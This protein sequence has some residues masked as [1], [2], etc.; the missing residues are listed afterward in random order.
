MSSSGT[1]S[2]GDESIKTI[3]EAQFLE[4]HTK[5]ES[6]FKKKEIQIKDR[7]MTSGVLSIQEKGKNERVVIIKQGQEMQEIE[8]QLKK[9]IKP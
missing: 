5:F 7:I 6:I 2:G 1:Y 4:I 3:S 9:Y 8:N